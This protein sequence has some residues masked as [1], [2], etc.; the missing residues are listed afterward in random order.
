MR[1]RIDGRLPAGVSA[2][3]LVIYVVHRLGAQ[4]ARGYAV[5]YV[6]QAV[7]G[8]SAEA[9]MPLDRKSV[10]MGQSVSVRVDRGGGRITKKTYTYTDYHHMRH[11]N[12][13]NTARALT[14]LLTTSTY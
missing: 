7:E 14:D 6:G 11:N 4:G 10:A 12:N 9:R 1:V 5:D 8:L 2:K 3:D 13:R